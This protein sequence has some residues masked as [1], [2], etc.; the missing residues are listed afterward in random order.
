VIAWIG[1]S[2]RDFASGVEN[3]ALVRRRSA[4]WWNAELFEAVPEGLVVSGAGDA[5]SQMIDSSVTRAHQQGRG[6][7]EKGAF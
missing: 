6:R 7:H 5:A 4:R 2:W 1:S 3:G